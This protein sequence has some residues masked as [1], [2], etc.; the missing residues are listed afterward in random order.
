MFHEQN[1]YIFFLTV[2]SPSTITQF[3]RLKTWLTFPCFPLS[4]PARISTWKKKIQQKF[5]TFLKFHIQYLVKVICKPRF[6]WVDFFLSTRK[7]LYAVI[8]QTTTKQHDQTQTFTVQCVLFSQTSYK[9][10]QDFCWF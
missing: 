4:F 10:S 7:H 8:T 6:T 9:L 5:K 1:I 2:L 3:L